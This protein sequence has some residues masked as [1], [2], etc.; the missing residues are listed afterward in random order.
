MIV[1]PIVKM[2]NN[3]TFL[4]IDIMYMQTMK[5]NENIFGLKRQV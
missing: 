5:V 4:T 2:I 3:H 1:N